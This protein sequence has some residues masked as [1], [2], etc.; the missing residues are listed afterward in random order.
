[1]KEKKTK[2]E[3][4]Y[5][6]GSLNVIAMAYPI[7]TYL[8]ADSIEDQILAVSVLIGAGLLLAVVDTISIAVRYSD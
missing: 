8:R 7:A 3:F 4:W 6:L 1:M 2:E 5:K